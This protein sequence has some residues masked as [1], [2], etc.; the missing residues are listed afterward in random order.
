MVYLCKII[1]T[2]RRKPDITYDMVCL[3]NTEYMTASSLS[4]QRQTQLHVLSEL[5]HSEGLFNTHI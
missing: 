4:T 5:Y 1:F 2:T 3:R